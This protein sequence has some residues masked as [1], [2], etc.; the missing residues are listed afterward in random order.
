VTRRLRKFRARLEAPNLTRNLRG[1]LTPVSYDWHNHTTPAL[2]LRGD[3]SFWRR[4]IPH[5]L[6]GRKSQAERRHSTPEGR[7][8]QSIG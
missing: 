4:P 3:D 2:G 1:G 7:S 6:P 5:S 8:R